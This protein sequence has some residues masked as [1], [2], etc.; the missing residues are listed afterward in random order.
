LP[1]VGPKT[2]GAAGGVLASVGDGR[3]A[4]PIRALN[5]EPRLFGQVVTWGWRYFDDRSGSEGLAE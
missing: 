5:Q 1:G 3:Q 2:T 4:S